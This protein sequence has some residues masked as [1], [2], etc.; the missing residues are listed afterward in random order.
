MRY[1]SH[2][3]WNKFS[4]TGSP[5]E[6]RCVSIQLHTSDMGSERC[7]LCEQTS[8]RKSI[9]DVAYDNN[10]SSSQQRL[11]YFRRSAYKCLSKMT[12]SPNWKHRLNK[13]LLTCRVDN[14][15]DDGRSGENLLMR[16]FQ[17][18][19]R[20]VSEVEQSLCHIRTDNNHF[21]HADPETEHVNR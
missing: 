9:T 15:S 13:A 16:K 2:Q 10:S 4:A 5:L 17:E 20:S 12:A 8:N 6:K 21:Y 18:T 11:N 7:S 1:D 19:A 14:I 3:C